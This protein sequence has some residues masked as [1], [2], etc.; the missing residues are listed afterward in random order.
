MPTSDILRTQG[1]TNLVINP[2]SVAGT[3]SD[4]L[5]TLGSLNDRLLLVEQNQRVR[6]EQAMADKESMLQML[7]T[8]M[9][10][11]RKILLTVN[12]NLQ[13]EPQQQFAAGSAF[14]GANAGAGAG[15]A[16]TPTFVQTTRPKSL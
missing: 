10:Y 2:R 12:Q 7:S 5:C 9:Q 4:I 3:L 13:M 16:G 15:G 8:T 1:N 14:S 11:Q 6:H